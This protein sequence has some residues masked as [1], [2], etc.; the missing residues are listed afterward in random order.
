MYFAADV[1]YTADDALVG[2]YSMGG[3]CVFHILVFI[4][5]S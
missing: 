5:Q 4:I 1:P 2:S 3:R